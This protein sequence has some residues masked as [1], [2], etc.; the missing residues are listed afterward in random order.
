MLFFLES[1][2]FLS[3]HFPIY[4]SRNAKKM[5]NFILTTGRGFRISKKAISKKK[6]KIRFS[7]EDDLAIKN[8]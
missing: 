6:K 8:D 4:L 5:T 2:T 3:D 7:L 1:F